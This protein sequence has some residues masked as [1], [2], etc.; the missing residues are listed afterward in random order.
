MRNSLACKVEAE[1]EAEATAEATA[2]GEGVEEP[3]KHKKVG[4]C[5]TGTDEKARTDW[6]GAS[7]AAAHTEGPRTLD[8]PAQ[9]RRT[10]QKK[11]HP[12]LLD[13]G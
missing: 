9:R 12:S 3:L 8:R 10:K 4:M 5:A 13:R 2:A 11:S 1:A 6:E 7:P